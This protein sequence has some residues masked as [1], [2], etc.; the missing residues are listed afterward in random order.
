MMVINFIGEFAWDKLV[1]FN[2]KI[3]GKIAKIIPQ[4]TKTN[5]KLF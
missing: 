4:K 2:D 5:N 3:V 1:V